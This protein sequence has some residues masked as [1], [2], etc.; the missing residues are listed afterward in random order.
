[1]MA[2]ST[3]T[4][5]GRV[6]MWKTPRVVSC[7]LCRGFG[8]KGDGRFFI[9]QACGRCRSVVETRRLQKA[10]NRES[11]QAGLLL[12][13]QQVSSGWSALQ[14]AGVFLFLDFPVSEPDSN[15]EF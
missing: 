14:V 11:I 3:P 6:N 9:R 15:A 1:M 5:K 13:M 7:G 12:N 4:Q 2:S 8:A 10:K